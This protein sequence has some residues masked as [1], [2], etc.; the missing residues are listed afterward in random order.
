[1]TESDSSKPEAAITQFGVWAAVAL[2]AF[3]AMMFGDWQ[4]RGAI[5][6]AHR[7]MQPPLINYDLCKPGGWRRYQN[8]L[9]DCEMRD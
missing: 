3:I 8:G 5:Q 2:V 6:E 1:M 9:I 4:A 7:K